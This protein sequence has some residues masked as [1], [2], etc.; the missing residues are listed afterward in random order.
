MIVSTAITKTNNKQTSLIYNC[1]DCENKVNDCTDLI[2]HM[3]VFIIVE[4][5]GIL[6]LNI[7]TN[8][9]D[10]NMKVKKINVFRVF[11]KT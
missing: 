10:Y 9:I 6:D 5:F 8:I 7:Q 11:V 4:S 2:R 1:R 3:K